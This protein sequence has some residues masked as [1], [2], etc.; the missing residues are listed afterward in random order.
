MLKLSFGAEGILNSFL[1]VSAVL[2]GVIILKVHNLFE[3]K[4]SA[5]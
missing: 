2:F 3:K 4:N 5:N 1:I